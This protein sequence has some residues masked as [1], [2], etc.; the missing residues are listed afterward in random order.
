MTRDVRRYV[1][2]A[3]GTGLLVA[4]GAGAVMTDAITGGALGATGIAATFL[5]VVAA[6]VACLG[7][8]SG[9]HL[10]PA[11]TVAFWSVRR[12]PG[13]EVLPYV[14]AQ[15]AGAVVGALALRAA[16][17]PV[18][19]VGA[20]VPRVP[21]VVAFGVEFVFS[22][23]LFLVIA[24][25]ATDPRTPAGVAPLAVGGTVGLCALQG[26]LTGASMN[27]ARSLGPAVAAA[28]YAAHWLY[29]AAPVAR[30]VAAARLSEWL[31]GAR[32]HPA[33]SLG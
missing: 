9:A 6:L 17:G 8:V 3:L 14:A 18:A 10:N 2:E 13:R 1:A 28:T 24:A 20:T 26:A 29:W 21:S 5:L 4:F 22:F 19:S 15:C 25:V 23:A 30:R 31:R 16:L 11:V 7:D 32:A 33:A 27:P 12:F